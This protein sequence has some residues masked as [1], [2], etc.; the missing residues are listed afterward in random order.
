MIRLLRELMAFIRGTFVEDCPRCHL[1][2]YGFHEWEQFVV[3][4]NK[5]YRYVCHRCAKDKTERKKNVV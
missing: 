2:F 1:H 3:V 5:N 4:D